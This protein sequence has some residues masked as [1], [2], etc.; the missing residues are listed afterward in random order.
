MNEE[1]PEIKIQRKGF[2]QCYDCAYR[3]TIPGNAHSKCLFDFK[4]ARIDMP[5]GD[6][7]GIKQ[8]WY[9]FPLN[10]DPVWMDTDC[11]GFAEQPDEDLTKV[12]D[13]VEDTLSLL[14]RRGLK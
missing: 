14:G 1:P 6:P 2:D 12:F 10:Y 13:V 9:I 11:G 8:G 4:K 5:A 7:Y 3:G